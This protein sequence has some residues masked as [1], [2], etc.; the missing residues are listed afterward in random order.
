MHLDDTCLRSDLQDMH[1]INIGVSYYPDEV[2]KWFCQGYN[3][4]HE[5]YLFRKDE[6]VAF[7]QLVFQVEWRTAAFQAPAL[8]EGDA[9]AEN[10]GL[11]QVM[12][13]KNDGAF[14]AVKQNDN[15]GTSNQKI[16][17]YRQRKTDRLW[18][19]KR[20]SKITRE[21]RPALAVLNPR[22]R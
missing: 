7:S 13:G 6:V 1:F 2:E 16:Y 22:L 12:G 11:I 3:R 18:T 10:L 14:W 9:I 20:C 17:W 19:K 21:T 8:Q 15:T 5:V 4:K